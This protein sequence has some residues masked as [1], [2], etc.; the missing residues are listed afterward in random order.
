[1]HYYTQVS[2]KTLEFCKQYTS[3]IYFIKLWH[4]QL[5]KRSHVK[6]YIHDFH[7]FKCIFP[8]ELWWLAHYGLSD[9]KLSNFWML[10]I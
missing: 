2:K 4:K 10:L 9:S 8:L 5:L 7:L 1:M 3:Y 6:N